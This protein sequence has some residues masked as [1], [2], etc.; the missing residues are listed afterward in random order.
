MEPTLRI[1]Q[2]MKAFLET[3]EWE[4]VARQPNHV[5]WMDDSKSKMF[6]YAPWGDTHS[7]KV[8]KNPIRIDTRG[9]KFKEVNN[10]FGFSSP[11]EA[12]STNPTWTVEGSKGAKYV[13]EKDGSVYTC[14]CPGFK[15]RGACRHIEEV[16]E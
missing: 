5:Y 15:F 8:F 9:R 12:V 3:T 13:V 10:T 7:V 2:I 16:Q 11:K 6:A 14:T 1:G 4:D